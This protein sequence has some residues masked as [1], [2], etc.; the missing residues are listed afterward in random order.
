MALLQDGDEEGTL[1]F[2]PADRAQVRVAI[3][4][5]G[6]KRKRVLSPAQREALA[7]ARA[8]SPLMRSGPSSVRNDRGRPRGRGEW[9]RHE[10]LAHGATART[11][12]R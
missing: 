1:L 11:W 7:K 3:K 9:G 4:A 2:D 10:R 12:E 8:R 6:A 5:V